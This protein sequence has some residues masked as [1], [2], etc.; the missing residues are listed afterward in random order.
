MDFQLLLL[1]DLCKRPPEEVKHLW[2]VLGPHL[3]H[4]IY[5]SNLINVSVEKAL[6]FDKVSYGA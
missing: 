1:Q 4:V 2:S 6:G 3:G 5:V